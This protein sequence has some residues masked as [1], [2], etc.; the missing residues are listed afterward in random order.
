MSLALPANVVSIVALAGASTKH[1]TPV[2]EAREV[3]NVDTRVGAANIR[4]R[5]LYLRARARES[6]PNSP[7]LSGHASAVRGRTTIRAGAR[8]PL[9]PSFQIING[10]IAASSQHTSTLS[11]TRS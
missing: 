9:P 8:S 5:R 7:I 4:G 2:T 1:G 11:M 6:R 3:Q 10:R